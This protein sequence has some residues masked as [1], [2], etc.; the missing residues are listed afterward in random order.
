MHRRFVFVFLAASLFASIFPVSLF[1]PTVEAQGEGWLSGWQYR[2]S[3]VINPASGAG[4]NYQVKIKALWGEL[5]E[6]NLVP[7]GEI[8]SMLPVPS[9][10]SLDSV[11]AA[12]YWDGTYLHVWYG[13]S[14]GGDINDSIYYTKASSPF[15]SWSTPILVI[16]RD[17]GIRDPTIFVEGNNIYLFCQCFDG[18][19]FRPIR[20]YKILK[21]ADFT[22][23]D[24]YAYVGAV[25]DLGSSGSY[26]DSMVASP[27]VV[28]IN[29]I[30]YLM[31]EAVGGGGFS[32]GR[33]KSSN[34]ESLPWI[35]DGQL[36]DTNG[37]VIRNPTNDL[38]AIVPDTF[39]DEDTLIIHYYDGTRWHERYVNGDFQNNSA[40]LSATDIDPDDGYPDHNNFAHIG[41][42][43]GFYYFL[44]QNDGGLHLYKVSTLDLA[45]LEQ[46]CR[47]DF[48]DVRF[49]ASDGT[50]L[51][52]YWMESKVNGDYAVFW[53]KVA[54]DLSSSNATVY[55]YYGKSDA[56]TT[57][58]AA[59]TF[60]FADDFRL[61]S[62]LDTGKWTK[63]NSPTISFDGTDGINITSTSYGARGIRQ[64]NTLD[65]TDK[66]RLLYKWKMPTTAKYDVSIFICP[67][68]VSGDPYFEPNW[69]RT[70]LYESP[71]GDRI[72]CQVTGSQSEP[73][74]QAYTED[75]S[76]YGYFATNG[77]SYLRYI[78]D[79]V[80]KYKNTT[81]G[82]G[83]GVNNY[84]YL[85]ASSSGG[86]V[87]LKMEFL[88]VTKYVDPEPSHGAWG[89]EEMAEPPVAIFT[90]LP[91][92]P[93]VSDPILFN[94]SLSSSNCG[95]I[96]NYKWS[97]GDGNVTPTSNR[98][99]VHVYNIP[100][101]YNITLTILDSVGLS[102]STWNV[103]IVSSRI[104]TMISISTFASSKFVG[105]NVKINGTLADAE[106]NGLSGAIVVLSHT[107]PGIPEWIPLTS[108]TTD[109][110]GNYDFTWIPPLTGQFTIK[111]EWAGNDTYAPAS[112]TSTLN[113]ITSEDGHVFSVA[114]NSTVSAL[115]FNS[116]DLQLGFT[117]TGPPG[118]TGFAQVTIAKTL[119]S[120]ITD[121]KV[122]LDGN[123]LEFS[124]SSTE[125]SWIVY[126]NYTHSTHYVT[127]ALNTTLGDTAMTPL[128]M[129][130]LIL[131]AVLGVA[132]TNA[133]AIRKLKPRFHLMHKSSND[134]RLG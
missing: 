8:V 106:G 109:A 128:T 91:A 87:T 42:I 124:T 130:V 119:A 23:P 6:K 110:L 108:A 82:L 18:S 93:K 44:M 133:L 50:T 96:V 32:I 16:D 129:A 9:G 53:V 101:T 112:N 56:T 85:V 78:K 26:D 35:K 45:S 125:D 80:Q 126:L 12:V 55:I 14:T 61:D 102:A 90:Y 28:K 40:T 79:D 46:H 89:N 72:Q 73:F 21:T 39:A 66:L 107:F 113:V 41:I 132:G 77:G 57:S 75:T 71:G 4:T 30:Y 49:T 70:N 27:C 94:A 31:Y 15:T 38:S 13:A 52:D 120:N 117:V 67:T 104:Q 29:S 5:T 122:Y 24:N 100:G 22:N 83:N 64:K 33:A 3:H 34:I 84:I 97:F 103:V 105:F 114:S 81:A 20:L 37:N 131:L 63:I 121:L 88:C 54:D 76:V 127:I 65:Y 10:T 17:D 86:A 69:V 111:T 134:K 2:K 48:G 60:V 95:A 7:F 116:T 115:A 68:S 19:N 58:N 1:I 11:Q 98:T 25:I 99:I 47:T 118:T 59:N 74:S 43:N 36:R 62:S 123:P 51:L 92:N